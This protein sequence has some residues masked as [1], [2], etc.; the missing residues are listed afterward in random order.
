MQ[1]L[2]FLE[3]L[4]LINILQLKNAQEWFKHYGFGMQSISD[5]KQ[6]II[7]ANTAENY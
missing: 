2:G 1:K 4:N 5:L 6:Y 7:T 3:T